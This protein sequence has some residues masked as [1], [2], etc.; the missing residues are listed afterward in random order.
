LRS[1]VNF[2]ENDE[3]RD[4]QEETKPDVFFGHF[5]HTHVCTDDDNTVIWRKTGEASDGSL[6]ILL[7]ATKISD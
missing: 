4:F 3:E 6:E 7:M 2:S 5:L 1:Q